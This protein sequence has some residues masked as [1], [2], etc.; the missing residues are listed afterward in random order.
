MAARVLSAGTH[1]IFPCHTQMKVLLSQSHPALCCC[2]GFT[3]FFRL[4]EA[5]PWGFMR[6]DPSFWV[7]ISISQQNT[8]I[9]Y[10][11]FSRASPVSWDSVVPGWVNCCYSWSQDHIMAMLSNFLEEHAIKWI[12]LHLQIRW[13]GSLNNLYKLWHTLYGRLFG[14]LVFLRGIYQLGK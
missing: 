2:T 14:S 7:I 4:T 3:N 12:A 11:S 9:I 10:A 8:C 1:Q 6:A 5:L 13:E